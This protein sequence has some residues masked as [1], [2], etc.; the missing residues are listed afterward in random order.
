MENQTI[1]TDEGI[2]NLPDFTGGSQ[3]ETD[4]RLLY[5]SFLQSW[6]RRSATE[7][8][9]LFADDGTYIGFDGS[10]MNGKTE[11]EGSFAEIFGMYATA[12]YV[13][14]L[15]QVKTLGI[16]GG[17]VT[18]YTGLVPAGRTDISPSMNALQTMVA[19][20]INGQWRIELLQNT[21]AAY[22][23]QPDQKEKLTA[24]LRKVLQKAAEMLENK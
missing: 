8:A 16:H 7:L 20:Q 22:H 3:Q 17:L 14:I 11:I 4:L 9:G 12:S 21:P 10:E 19:R 5:L 2:M 18:A 1:S 15:K 23:L 13:V 6:N 24:D